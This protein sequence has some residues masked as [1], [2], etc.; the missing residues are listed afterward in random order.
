[1]ARISTLAVN[2]S[3]AGTPDYAI[4]ASFSLREHA[5]SRQ[6]WELGDGDAF[7]AVVEFRGTSG[8]VVAAAALGRADE[9]SA[10]LRRFDVRRAD[11]FA[12]WLFS[13][14][15]DAIPVSPRALVDEYAGLATRT[16]AL[17]AREAT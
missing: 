9:T 4:P 2:A 1:V 6:A 10:V 5:Q 7:E 11:S 14:A 12:R 3:R 16:R 17:Y 13:F 15:G 8:A